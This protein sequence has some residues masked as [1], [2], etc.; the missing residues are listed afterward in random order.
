MTRAHP[1]IVDVRAGFWTPTVN[2]PSPAPFQLQL[3]CHDDIDLSALTFQSLH[4]GF[5]DNRP[6]AVVNASTDESDSV[7]SQIDLGTIS[8]F[9]AGETPVAPLRWS[10]RGS[11]VLAGHLLSEDIAE[12]QVSH[13]FDC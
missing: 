13:S 7:E 12:V 8:A 1:V 11:I 4:V 2:L 10:K 6:D 5:S 9:E 3:T